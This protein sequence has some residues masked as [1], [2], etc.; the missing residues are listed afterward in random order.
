MESILDLA[1][2]HAEACALSQTKQEEIDLNI[3]TS[4]Q[5][6]IAS[7]GVKIHVRRV[8]AAMKRD[9]ERGVPT[10]YTPHDENGGG[11]RP[12]FRSRKHRR[13]YLKM[14]GVH[15]NDGGFGDG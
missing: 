5:K 13:D 12:I 4:W 14:L 9:A 2:E 3:S 11:G 7:D 8:P 1:K 15:D 6:P 10:E